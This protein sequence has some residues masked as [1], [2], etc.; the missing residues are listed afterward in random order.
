MYPSASE[1]S[2]T[3]CIG[4]MVQTAFGSH[5]CISNIRRRTT[6]EFRRD[7]AFRRIRL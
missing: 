5:G 4:F 7:R 1:I 6:S 3:Q 2:G